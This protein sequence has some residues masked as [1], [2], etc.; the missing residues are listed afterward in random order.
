MQAGLTQ[1][2]DYPEGAGRAPDGNA[3]NGTTPK[4]LTTDTGTLDLAI[5]RDRQSSFQPQF[6]P[7]GVRRLQGFDETVLVLYARGLTVRE[8]QAYPGGA[9][10]GAG[11]A[12]P[13]QHRDARGPPRGRDVEVAPAGTA[14]HRCA[15]RCLACEDARREGLDQNKAV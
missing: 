7:K 2:L 6:V 10:P 14:L 13:D 5:P 1:H 4:T 9:L 11:V 8:L 12:G 3:R 15:V